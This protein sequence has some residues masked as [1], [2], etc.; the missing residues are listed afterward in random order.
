MQNYVPKYAGTYTGNTASTT[1]TCSSAATYTAPNTNIYL[2]CLTYSYSTSSGGLT[3]SW[4]G[5]SMT[6]LSSALEG[7]YIRLE[8]WGLQ[9]PAAK[10]GIAS[11]FSMTAAN[12]YLAILGWPINGVVTAVG[13]TGT[14]GN[15]GTASIT[16]STTTGQ[17]VVGGV[18][19]WN[20]PTVGSGTQIGVTETGTDTQLMA[21]QR[22]GSQ[23]GTL[24]TTQT[25]TYWTAVAANL[26][27]VT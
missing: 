3:A 19:T 26:K 16:A 4:N 1:T 13:A 12:G 7:T 21:L 20:A 10:V 6:G 23:G 18:G 14:N 2:C 27:I 15:S 9:V 22:P 17:L 5:L 25:S 8:L 24:S 11:A